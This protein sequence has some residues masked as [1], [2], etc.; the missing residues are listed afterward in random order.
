MFQ[1]MWQRIIA[2]FLAIG[3]LAGVFSSQP[4]FS[5]N[6]GEASALKQSPVQ[7]ITQS[8]SKLIPLE[9]FFRKP[10]KASFN[11]S[12]NGEHLAY[13]QPWNNRMNVHVQLNDSEEAVRITN[14]TEQDVLGFGWITNNRLLYMFDTG[15]DENYRLFAVNADGTDPKE[16]TPNEGI[17]AYPLDLLKGNTDEILIQMNQRDPRVFDVYRLNIHTADLTL[18]AENPGYITDWL[19]DHEGQVRVAVGTEGEKSM[20]LYRSTEE[21]DF[22]IIRTFQHDD[23]LHPL[24]FAYDDPNAIYALSNLERDKT[25]LV[26]MDLGTGDITDTIFEHDTVDVSGVI[27]SD[28]R[29]KL[30]A[31]SYVT[32][33]VHY[34]FFDRHT[35]KL[36]RKVEKLLPQYRVKLVHIG[37]EEKNAVVFASN[38]KSQGAYYKYDANTKELKLLAKLSGWLNEDDLADMQAIQ[39]KARDGLKINGYLTL[40]KGVAARNLPVVI[41]PHGG[42]WARDTWGYNPEVQF[43]A[44][45]GYAVLQMNFRG[46]TGYGRE[47][48]DAGNKEWGKA[49]Q[50]DITDGVEWLIEK[51]IAD[52]GRIAIYGA[53]Y[54]GYATLAGVTFTPDLYAAGISYVGPSNLFTLLKSLPPYWESGRTMFHERVGHPVKDKKLLEEISPLFH[55]EQIKTPL[56]IVQG[57]NDPRVKQEE[58]DQIV[59]AL[60]ERGIEVPYMLKEDEGHGFRKQENVFDFYHALEEFLATHLGEA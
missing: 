46:S 45:R 13:L 6:I 19:T 18:I 57:A 42:P 40:P 24:L 36:Q 49:M 55:V 37:D 28:Q 27:S 33:E 5:H 17:K 56:F 16:L 1:W 38:D 54:G 23:T 14:E 51:G 52:P 12:P 11:V 60:Q 47:F 44:N 39:Y 21:E 32:N 48:L 50:D 22:K 20:L 31:A 26:K 35:K 8:H 41:H 10:D 2:S 4:I 43:L 58:S 53:S 30:L 15:G 7:A 25:A 59:E 9:D 34:E 3:L 29:K